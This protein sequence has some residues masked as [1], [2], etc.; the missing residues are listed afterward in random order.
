[1]VKGKRVHNTFM[2]PPH[3]DSHISDEESQ[4]IFVLVAPKFLLAAALLK[5]LIYLHSLLQIRST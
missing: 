5:D 3:K 4:M 2:S 1:M